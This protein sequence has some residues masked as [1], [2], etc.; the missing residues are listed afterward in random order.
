MGESAAT[1]ITTTTFFLTSLLLT[2]VALSSPRWIV[3]EYGGTLGST[4]SLHVLLGADAS[5]GETEFGLLV[6][7]EEHQFR[8]ERR[9][10]CRSPQNLSGT[11]RVNT[12]IAHYVLQANGRRRQCSCFLG[13]FLWQVCFLERV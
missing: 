1:V 6:E 2:F 3:S 11:Y 7:C 5:A 8:D 4:A 10:T 9:T 13:P 12:L